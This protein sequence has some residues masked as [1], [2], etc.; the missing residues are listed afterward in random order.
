MCDQGGKIPFG[1]SD[2]L[3]GPLYSD[4]FGKPK[5]PKALPYGKAGKEYLQMLGAYTAGLP[6]QEQAQAT[7][8]P[9]YTNL[10]LQSLEQELMGTPGTPG[11]LDI[12]SSQV[13]PT[14]ATATTRANTITRGANLN[15]ITA[16]GPGAA[17]AVRALNPG[18]SGL[19]DS[20]TK[21]ATNQL[22]LGTQ[23]DPATSNHR[24]RG[25]RR[26][27]AGRGL[28]TSQPASMDELLQLYAGGQNLLGGREALAGKTATMTNSMYTDPAL[29][30]LGVNSPVPGQAQSMTST[31]NT[32]ATGYG[33]TMMPTN[34]LADMLGTAYN[35]TAAASI[36]AGNNKAALCSAGIGA[37]GSIIGGAAGGMGG[38]MGA[39]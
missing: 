1:S 11:Y 12:Y 18:Q 2:P 19:M 20:L 32:A 8:G 38:A 31:G 24:G 7:Y 33:P 6:E 13:A 36:A 25:V 39:M 5:G 21:T 29:E 10:G 22:N 14:L 37:G 15:D 3:M 9:Q 30:L 16:M 27:W 34:D 28:G 4:V 26:D 17:G 35:E 23:V